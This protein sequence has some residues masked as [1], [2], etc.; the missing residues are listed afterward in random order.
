M[1]EWRDD[2]TDS[3][4]RRPCRS[5]RKM[6][7]VE[8]PSNGP[9]GLFFSNKRTNMT[10]MNILFLYECRHYGANC[11]GI[12]WAPRP[13]DRARVSATYRSR[14]LRQYDNDQ[15]RRLRRNSRSNDESSSYRKM[16]IYQLRRSYHTLWLK[17]RHKVMHRHPLM[18]EFRRRDT[19]NQHSSQLG[20]ESA[21]IYQASLPGK[22][23]FNK[24]TYI[25][26]HSS[27]LSQNT[28]GPTTMGHE[29]GP[30]SKGESQRPRPQMLPCLPRWS[31]PCRWT[32]EEGR[33]GELGWFIG[34]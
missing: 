1:V 30:A 22:E 27:V 28:T 13:I 12:G 5:W 18:Q 29:R 4:R 24:A 16:S 8:F 15:G 26:R 14:G 3:P 23:H 25:L 19:D 9:R 34:T 17:L 6:I 2:Q 21:P 31:R 7:F 32:K 11:T 33:I 20:T 10:S